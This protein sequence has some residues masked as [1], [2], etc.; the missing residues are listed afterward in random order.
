MTKELMSLPKLF[1]WSQMV[2]GPVSAV[3]VSV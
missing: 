1:D 3:L 2:P